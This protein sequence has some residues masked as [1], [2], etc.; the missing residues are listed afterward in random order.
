MKNLL[1]IIFLFASIQAF[2][3]STF[4]IDGKTN[5][6]ANGKAV[7]NTMGLKEFGLFTIKQDT[8]LVHNHSFVFTGTLKYPGECRIDIIA[9]GDLHNL[10]EPFFIS[11]GNHKLTIDKASNPHDIME[12]GYGVQLENSPV[13]DEYIKKYLPAYNLVSKR[14]DDY[15][16]AKENCNSIKDKNVR[17]GCMVAADAQGASIRKSSD[18][19][20]LTYAKANPKSPIVP[21]LLYDAF[22]IKGYSECFEDVLK[23]VSTYAPPTMIPSIRSRLNQ[24]KLKSPGGQFALANFVKANTSKNI[25]QNKYVLV[26]FWFSGCKPCIAQFDKLKNVYKKFH[27]KGF[28]ITAISVD[29]KE[30]LPAYKELLARKNYPWLQILDI[31][32]INAKT[33]GIAGY[34]SGFLL[35]SHWKIVK[36]NLESDALNS[37]LEDHL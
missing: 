37:F 10:S 28:E 11:A 5:V 7:L 29:R 31:S 8:V 13:N 1:I 14:L 24:L 35:D 3:Q 16:K 19:V 9:K 20:L 4:V 2:S 18:N 15:H 25:S 21:W 27:E 30:T 33:M 34:P 12:I 36:T 26:D 32:G 6:L 23:E 22:F 17:K